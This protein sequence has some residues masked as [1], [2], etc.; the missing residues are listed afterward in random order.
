[1]ARTA[2]H[3]QGGSWLGGGTIVEHC[4]PNERTMITNALNDIRTTIGTC[5]PGD[6]A[7][8]RQRINDMLA[9]ALLIDCNAA[10]CAGL[11]GFTPVRGEFRVTVCPGPFGSQNRTNA[12]LFHEMVHAAGG[13]ELDA[14]A[15]ENH[16]YA[17]RGAV[18]P[19][20]GDFPLFRSDG[21]TWTIWD[22]STGEVFT[23]RR[24]G[25]SWVGDPVRIVRGDRLSVNFQP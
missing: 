16:C 19:T 24:E 12:V 8:L 17:G 21:G 13:T 2:T 25:G 14:E 6:A 23:K 18:A 22:E 9:S 7:D 4:S 5:I 10:G 1:M 15:F 20:P 3:T 11:D